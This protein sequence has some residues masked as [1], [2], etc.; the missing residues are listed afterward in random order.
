MGYT[1]DFNSCSRTPY[2]TFQ[3]DYL[4][5]VLSLSNNDNND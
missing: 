5:N 1:I 4:H 2:T 3:F